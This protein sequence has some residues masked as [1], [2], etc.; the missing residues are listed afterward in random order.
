MLWYL[1]IGTKP[2]RARPVKRTRGVWLSIELEELI[3]SGHHRGWP[4]IWALKP[5]VYCVDLSDGGDS[6]ANKFLHFFRDFMQLL[7]RH[8]REHRQRNNFRGYA[9]ADRKIALLAVEVLVRFLRC[10][11]IG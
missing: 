5:V 2:F 1:R 7:I 9:L 3:Q 8:L 4:G 10:N 11:G 6:R